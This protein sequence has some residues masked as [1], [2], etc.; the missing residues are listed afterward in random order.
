MIAPAGDETPVITVVKPLSLNPPFP[1]IYSHPAALVTSA[2][3]PA[4]Y[5]PTA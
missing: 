4:G 1:A 5:H 2:A 3:Y